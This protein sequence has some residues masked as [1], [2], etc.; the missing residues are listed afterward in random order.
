MKE[1]GFSFDNVSNSEFISKLIVIDFGKLILFPFKAKLTSYQSNSIMSQNIF[2]F[3]FTF[4]GVNVP[5]ILNK[6]MLT[7]VL[8]N[9]IS[10]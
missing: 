4:S 9:M 6:C 3:N 1:Q 5:V 7:A 10:T 8:H 2:L